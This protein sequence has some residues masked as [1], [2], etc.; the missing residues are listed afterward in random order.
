VTSERLDWTRLDAAES[1][2]LGEGRTAFI[3]RHSSFLRQQGVLW[4]RRLSPAQTQR[5]VPGNVSEDP[6]EVLAP[7]RVKGVPVRFSDQL[8]IVLL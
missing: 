1:I 5:E 4:G 3:G 7:P 6:L 2:A 8:G